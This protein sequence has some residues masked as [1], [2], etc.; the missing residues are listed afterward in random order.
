MA[1]LSSNRCSKSES[2]IIFANL[3]VLHLHQNHSGAALSAL[4]AFLAHFFDVRSSI[5][6]ANESRAHVEGASRR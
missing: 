5:M 3:S 6:A 4:L 2:K 1:E